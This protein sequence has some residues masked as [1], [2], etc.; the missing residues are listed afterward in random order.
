MRNLEVIAKDFGVADFHLNAGLF[1]FLLFQ[2]LQKGMAVGRNGTDF[3]EFRRKTIADDAAVADDQS[4][5]VL[6]TP[7]EQVIHVVVSLQAVIQGVQ[8]VGTG[9]G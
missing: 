7:A 5:F 3:I 8:E 9:P 1:L 2:F 6:D 4:R